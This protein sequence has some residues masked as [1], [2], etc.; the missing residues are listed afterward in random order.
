MRSFV[1]AALAAMALSGCGGSHPAAGNDAEQ[2]FWTAFH[3]QDFGIT[4]A[5][6]QQLKAAHD[7][8]PKAVETER[9]LGLVHLWRAAEADR[10]PPSATE[11]RL[12]SG[13]IAVPYL[14]EVHAADPGDALTS[15][16]LALDAYEFGVIT[17]EPTKIAEGKA[18]MD[19]A[20]AQD[21]ITV[22]FGEMFITAQLPPAD[23]DVAKGVDVM[24]HAIELCTNATIDRD[25]PDLSGLKDAI[26]AARGKR[27]CWNSPVAP[28]TLE[29]V[30]FFIGDNYLKMN[31]VDVAKTWYENAQSSESYSTWPHKPVV[32]S[33]LASDLG[34]R[35][36]AYQG[37]ATKWPAIGDPPYLC[38]VCHGTSGD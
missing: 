22:A 6:A 32:E 19:A 23:P 21:P 9:L 7:A 20:F 36:A 25:H 26:A 13:M 15:A 34:A 18:M 16:F 27:F 3:A 1:L 31:R 12:D 24:V 11:T 35:A 4:G 5:V 14:N 8:N 29:G 10:D 38:G 30:F 33:R 2:S 17:N 28:H 37:D